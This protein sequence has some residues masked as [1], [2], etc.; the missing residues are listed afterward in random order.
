MSTVFKNAFK[1]MHFKPHMAQKPYG[2]DSESWKERNYNQYNLKR[3]LAPASFYT[4]KTVYVF[5]LH[6]QD[7][8]LTFI[9]DSVQLIS[10]IRNTYR[11]FRLSVLLLR[12]KSSKSVREMRYSPPTSTAASSPEF[13]QARTV[14]TF[15]FNSLAISSVVS[16]L[17][18]SGICVS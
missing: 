12:I 10:N 3:R 15:T 4:M 6:L 1:C 13:I 18:P 8:Y 7:S 16:Q 17:S 5:V 2:V 11:F 14:F 9:I